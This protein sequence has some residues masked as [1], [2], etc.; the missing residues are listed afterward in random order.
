MIRK[1]ALITGITGQDGSYL[2]EF[3]LSQGYEVHG[4]VRQAVVDDQRWLARIRPIRDRIALHGADLGDFDA[5]RQVVAAACPS[6]CYHLA[7]QSF[8]SYSIADEAVTIATNISATQTLL[9]ALLATAPACRFFFASSSEMFG[10]TSVSPQTEST[11]VSP[12]SVYGITKAAGFFLTRQ[13]R[14]DRGMFATSGILYNHESP[15]RGAGFV[16]RKISSSVARIAAGSADKLRLGNLDSR[17]DWG[18]A[19]DY[20]SAMWL[21]LQR[22]TPADYVISTGITHTVR[23]FCDLAFQRVG[24]RYED[25]VE[26]DPNLYRPADPIV[27][28]GNPMRA[29]TDLGWQATTPFEDLVNEMV[30]N[31]CKLAGVEISKEALR[32]SPV[33]S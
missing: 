5:V 19:R 18:H 10:R 16:T 32:L 24:L 12:R 29:R 7:A 27:L 13:Y 23:D 26:T 4:V 33:Y 21:M 17:R 20:V 2:A 31:D 22:A 30:D 8:V 15:R 14:D 25:W 9:A 6:E 1:S 28:T 3:L 11:P